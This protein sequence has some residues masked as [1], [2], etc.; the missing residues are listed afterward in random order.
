M[1]DGQAGGR[2]GRG[3]EGVTGN[4]IS[5]K[6]RRYPPP[7][8]RVLVASLFLQLKLV[9]N[10]A[11]FMGGGDL[12]PKKA[13]SASSSSLSSRASRSRRSSCRVR[14]FLHIQKGITMN[15][16]RPRGG[17]NIKETSWLGGKMG[18]G[19][20]CCARGEGGGDIIE[21]STGEMPKKAL[22]MCWKRKVE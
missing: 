18:Q 9:Q 12:S 14:R 4:I 10:A 15:R 22:E 1:R 7:N 17:V 2:G 11:E 19:G 8:V 13:A 6:N 20:K 16:T 3:G 5:T 21:V